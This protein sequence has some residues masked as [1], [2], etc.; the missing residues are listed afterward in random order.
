MTTH[1]ANLHV[2]EAHL[3][4]ALGIPAEVEILSATAH[5][6]PVQVFLLLSHPDFPEVLTGAEATPVVIRRTVHTQIGQYTSQS[7]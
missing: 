3:R 6:N 4:K 1:R 5:S 7:S 2:S